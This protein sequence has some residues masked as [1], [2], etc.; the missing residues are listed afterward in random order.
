MT[1]PMSVIA[2]LL[3]SQLFCLRIS[4]TYCTQA[5]SLLIGYFSWIYILYFQSTFWIAQ[6]CLWIMAVFRQHFAKC[7]VFSVIL[8][9]SRALFAF[10]RFRQEQQLGSDIT[11]LAIPS[12][13]IKQ[14]K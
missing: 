5:H 4:A 12:F 9:A 6:S 11:C 8:P 3:L 14:Q 2:M 1:S 7:V 13:G 10:F